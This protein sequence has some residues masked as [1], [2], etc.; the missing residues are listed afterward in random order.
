[1][2]FALFSALH[3]SLQASI[4]DLS[5]ADYFFKYFI[6]WSLQKDFAF[7]CPVPFLEI[8]KGKESQ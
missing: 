5:A 4:V 8:G 2:L 6:F 3:C 1:M 7:P